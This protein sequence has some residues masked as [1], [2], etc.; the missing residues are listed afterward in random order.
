VVKKPKPL[1]HFTR[2]AEA[3]S[4]NQRDPRQQASERPL[5]AMAVHIFGCHPLWKFIDRC[6]SV[7]APILGNRLMAGRIRHRANDA[8]ARCRKD[9][10]GE[11]LGP[12]VC[13][14]RITVEQDHQFPCR[15]CQALVRS[16]RITTGVVASV[17]LDPG[18]T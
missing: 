5:L 3:E 4:V 1:D 18:R 14:G 11:L 7:A 16:Q 13:H 17:Q 9:S 10:V 6:L 15:C 2:N 12:A 8:R